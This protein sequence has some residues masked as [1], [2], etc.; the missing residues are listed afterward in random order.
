MISSSAVSNSGGKKKGFPKQSEDSKSS[1]TTMPTAHAS[2]PIIS[3]TPQDKNKTTPSPS[4]WTPLNL[5]RDELTLDYTLP[6]GQSFRWRRTGSVKNRNGEEETLFTGVVGKRV[7]QLSHVGESGQAAFRV[8]VDKTEPQASSSS[9]PSDVLEELSDYFNA[10]VALAPMAARWAA[11]DARWR[12]AARVARGAR[13]LRQP[14][15]ECL[16]SFVCSS[17]N[18]IPRI[19]GMVEHLARRYGT[20]LASAEEAARLLSLEDDDDDDD[21]DVKVKKEKLDDDN[22]NAPA[23]PS[24]S[25]H[26]SPSPSPSS[27][28]SRS[29]APPK[30]DAPFYAFPTLDQLV[31]GNVNEADLREAGFGYRARYIVGTVEALASLREER[32]RRT[33]KKDGGEDDDF[34]LSLRLEPQER[35]LEELAKLPGVGPKVAACVALFSLDKHAV[36]PVGTFFNFFFNFFC[37]IFYSRCALSFSSGFPFSLLRLTAIESVYF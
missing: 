23:T 24:S 17:N 29:G 2:S 27:A 32:R 35:A 36:V 21:G 28:L 37:T 6:T 19:T 7:V 4:A 14:P 16:L 11:A 34:L 22:D 13:V 15:L 25:S 30:P 1:M 18:S 31:G 12:S 3:T 8:L 26:P 9:S 10:R 33:T 20:E 5:P